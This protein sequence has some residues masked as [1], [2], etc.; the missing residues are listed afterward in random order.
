MI[1]GSKCSGLVSAELKEDDEEGEKES[2][3]KVNVQTHMQTVACVVSCLGSS[4]R[5][6]AP[7]D[8]SN[9]LVIR[10]RG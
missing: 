3:V 7:G 4:G 10:G 5:S 8:D 6:E 2:V 1:V 9:R